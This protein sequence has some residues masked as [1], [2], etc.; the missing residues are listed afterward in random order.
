MANE[1][2]VLVYATA[3]D[4]ATA[5]RICGHLLERRLIACANILPGMISVY[6]WQGEMEEAREVAI[7][8]KT[9]RGQVD[10]AITAFAGE[11]PYE[12]PAVVVIETSGGLPA[13]LRWLA[14]ETAGP[15]T[16]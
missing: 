1:S 11:H 14:D 13:F 2:A 8:I 12:T 6:R 10:A 3:P 15:T 16:S 7:I 5:L 4:E 9:T